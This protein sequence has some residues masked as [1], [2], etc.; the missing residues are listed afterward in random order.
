MVGATFGAALS[1]TLGATFGWLGLVMSI[2]DCGFA[3]LDG[4]S[5]VF[6]ASG[7]SILSAT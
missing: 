1:A 5:S 7:H 6:G 2:L 4:E 3:I